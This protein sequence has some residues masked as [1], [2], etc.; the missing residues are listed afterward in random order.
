MGKR[1]PLP[2]PKH[3]K[4][5]SGKLPI[6]APGVSL[7]HEE[8]EAP[9]PPEDFDGDH[10]KVWNKTIE[11]LK[12]ARIL[13]SVD[14]AVLGAY[15][16]SYVRWRTAEDEIRKASKKSKLRGLL[17]EGASGTMIV[18]PLVSISRH[19]KNDMVAY[20]VQLGMTPSARMKMNSAM[21]E[22]VNK[23]VNAF[24]KLKKV[25]DERMGHK[26]KELREVIDS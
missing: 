4:V 16:C 11:L 12:A 26:G 1:G 23:K 6:G 15:C 5:L 25:S 22:E 9:D 13:K 14:T 17:A 24:V 7:E 18:N 19:E 21:G 8:F 2:K 20:A 10:L 3:L